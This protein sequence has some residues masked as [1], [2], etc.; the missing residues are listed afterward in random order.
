MKRYL[1]YDFDNGNV[2]KFINHEFLSEEECI[3]ILKMK[4]QSFPIFKQRQYLICSLKKGEPLKIE[5]FVNGT[6]I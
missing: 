5:Q 1:I 4:T 3:V 6:E 2:R